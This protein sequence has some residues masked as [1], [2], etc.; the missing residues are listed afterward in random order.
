VFTTKEERAAIRN[1]LLAAGIPIDKDQSAGAEKGLRIEQ[2]SGE[3][4]AMALAPAGT[5][6]ILDIRVVAIHTSLTVC[7][8]DLILP[9]HDEEVDWAPDPHELLPAQDSYRYPRQGI[10]F[11]RDRCINHLTGKLGKLSSQRRFIQG[12]LVGRG[13]KS[14]PDIYCHGS[15]VKAEVLALDEFDRAHPGRVQLFVDRTLETDRNSSKQRVGEGFSAPAR[16]EKRISP[17]Y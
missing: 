13:P 11:D 2:Q 8:F 12:L 10:E 17:A 9:W 1:R 4:M 6:Y 16:G 3:T 15:S 14:I 7:H 5:I